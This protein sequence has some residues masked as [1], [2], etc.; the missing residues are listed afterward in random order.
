MTSQQIPEMNYNNEFVHLQDQRFKKLLD[1]VKDAPEMV[2]WLE[3]MTTIS[4]T[5]IEH[6]EARIT[7]ELIPQSP[8]HEKALVS[9]QLNQ[10]LHLNNA[11]E[12]ILRNA[13]DLFRKAQIYNHSAKL[14]SSRLADYYQLL[15]PNE[16]GLN[17]IVPPDSLD[18]N[19][20]DDQQDRIKTVIEFNN[21]L[22]DVIKWFETMIDTQEKN[23]RETN[24]LIEK[25][26]TTEEAEREYS[27]IKLMLKTTALQEAS[28][29]DMVSN[30]T[31]LLEKMN[32]FALAT[33]EWKNQLGQCVEKLENKIEINLGTI[34]TGLSALYTP[35]DNDPEA[36]GA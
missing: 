35:S 21:Q 16:P 20:Q 26:W 32:A 2:T 10:T 17:E 31:V 3:N 1:F 9:G 6:A 24:A 22:P 33:T 11:S 18:A 12:I 19:L 4:K 7:G 15:D 8:D 36:P 27:R 14:L 5:D 25:E 29:Q 23:K 28:A 13:A 30:F 34:K